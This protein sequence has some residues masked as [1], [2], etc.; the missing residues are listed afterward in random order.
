M[1]HN[2]IM[3]LTIILI[4][5]S[6]KSVLAQ[7]WNTSVPKKILILNSSK[8]YATAKKVAIEASKKLKL[9]LNI[10]DLKPNKKTGLTHSEADCETF[11]Y[12]CYIARGEGDAQNNYYI[13]IE[14]S[15]AYEGFAQG[16]YIVVAGID[17][18]N[19]SK[20][21]TELARVK[22]YYKTAYAKGTKVWHG[23]MH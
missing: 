7:E 19:S 17:E 23:C 1:K 12:P 11:G 10:K 13:S 3:L 21:K 16:Y 9:E 5:F 6:N 8:D 22:K 4:S 2:L 14:Y 15:N 18:P 20:L